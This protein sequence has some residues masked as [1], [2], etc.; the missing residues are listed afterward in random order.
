MLTPLSGIERGGGM[1]ENPVVRLRQTAIF[2]QPL[3]SGESGQVLA[4]RGSLF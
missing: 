4:A 2:G 3:H 1:S